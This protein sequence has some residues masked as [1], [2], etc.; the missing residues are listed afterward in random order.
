MERGWLRHT[1]EQV[2]YKTKFTGRG[3]VELIVKKPIGDNQKGKKRKCY[4]RGQEANNEIRAVRRA[5][6][7]ERIKFRILLA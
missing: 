2:V 6:R 4:L 5:R 3:K 7:C 1:D